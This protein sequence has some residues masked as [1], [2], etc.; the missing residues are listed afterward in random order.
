MKTK[1]R[2]ENKLS[3][4]TERAMPAINSKPCFDPVTDINALNAVVVSQS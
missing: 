4:L 3:Q 1:R 2:I